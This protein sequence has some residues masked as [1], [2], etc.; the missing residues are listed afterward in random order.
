MPDKA[1]FDTNILVYAHDQS[2]GRKHDRTRDL[3]RDLWASGEG[4]LSIQVL[5]EFFV[6]VTRKVANPL[7]SEI[8]VQIITDLSVWQ[9]HCPGVDDVLAA[10]RLQDRYRVSFWDAMII[11]SAVALGCETIWSEDLNPGHVYDSVQ[12][13]SPFG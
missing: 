1:F 5:Q 2:A 3:V 13:Q 9:V 4:C 8:A 6:T 11:A 12:V 7:S 10:I